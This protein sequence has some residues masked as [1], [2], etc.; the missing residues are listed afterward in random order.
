TAAAAEVEHA[1][2]AVRAAAERA[3][4]A[5]ARRAEAAAAVQAAER[6]RERAAA[7]VAALEQEVARLQEQLAGSQ[8]D[9]EPLRE[10][11]MR[12]EEERGRLEA[13]LQQAETD[14]RERRRLRLEAQAALA[15]LERD[16]RTLEQ[17]VQEAAQ[18][19]HETALQV[20]QAQARLDALLAR[21]RELYDVDADA[22]E[23]VEPVRDPG[24]A[25]RLA[26]LR[27]ELNALGAVD[28]DAVALYEEERARYEES[29]R[30]LQDLEAARDHLIEILE[31]LKRRMDALFRDTLQA[32]R[33][34]FRETFAELFGGGEADLVPVAPG[35]REEDAGARPD[36]AGTAA[37]AGAAA[38]SD[39]AGAG[40]PVA[41]LVVRARPPGKRTDKLTLLSGG[42]RALTAI[43][44]LFALLKVQPAPFCVL[45]EIDAALDEANVGR[46]AEFLR[47]MARRTQFVIIT[48]QKGTME[49]ADRLFGVTMAERGVSQVVSVTLTDAG[50]PA[51][52]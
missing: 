1:E 20:A 43:A 3:L 37:A 38:G 7:D 40:E 32:V 49:A 23:R 45:D 48:H 46:F 52:A 4:A 44:L 12:A 10:A 15:E 47:Q 21:A 25:S 36:G 18:A 22:L 50:E 19:A 13:A 8:A 31:A 39:A 34:A 28:R 41:G 29:S 5:G 24:A 26:A 42:E 9:L 33:A 14:L 11:V 27:A 51:T 6:A 17:A 30:D 35:E 2:A 16:R